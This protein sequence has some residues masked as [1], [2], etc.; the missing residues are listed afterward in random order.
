MASF[1]HTFKACHVKATKAEW[2]N[3]VE[4]MHSDEYDFPE[5]FSHTLNAE[6][7]LPEFIIDLVELSDCLVGMNTDETDL[8]RHIFAIGDALD[9]NANTIKEYGMMVLYY[10]DE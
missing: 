5:Y 3:L 6:T 9:L 4:I 10:E 1:E 2:Q 8:N 7:H